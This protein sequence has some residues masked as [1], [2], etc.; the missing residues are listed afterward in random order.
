MFRERILRAIIP[1]T[2]GR[3]PSVRGAGRKGCSSSVALGLG[4]PHTHKKRGCCAIALLKY[5]PSTFAYPLLLLKKG[6]GTWVREWRT[7][8]AHMITGHG[9]GNDKSLCVATPCRQASGPTISPT[10]RM[11]GLPGIRLQLIYTYL[12]CKKVGRGAGGTHTGRWRVLQWAKEDS[13]GAVLA[14]RPPLGLALNRVSAAG[15]Q[16]A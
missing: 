10:R 1:D 12:Q 7:P 9:T 6:C 2:I 5:A 8:N 11:L 16:S 4:P 3:G 15:E 13:R 14:G